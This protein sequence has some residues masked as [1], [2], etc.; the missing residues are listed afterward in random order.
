VE[1]KENS[2]PPL[3]FHKKWS[4]RLGYQK[5]VRYVGLGKQDNRY[6]NGFPI[7]AM[8]VFRFPVTF[9]APRTR[10]VAKLLATLR[11]LYGDDYLEEL[12]ILAE[13]E[14]RKMRKY[15]VWEK[16]LKEVDE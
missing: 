9:Y 11:L 12:N 8:V 4:H 16:L 14:Y 6:S 3:F 5:C 15:K 7:V 1:G 2:S 10:E 13:R